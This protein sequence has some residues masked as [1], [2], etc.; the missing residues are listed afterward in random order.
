MQTISDMIA[1]I[2]R[3]ARAYVDR[4]P[5][6]IQG[7]NG[8]GKTWAVAIALARGFAL[9]ESTVLAILQDHN[10]SCDPPWSL[11]ELKHK[12]KDACEKSTLGCGYLLDAERHDMGPE[13]YA[14]SDELVAA[15]IANDEARGLAETAIVKHDP[16]AEETRIQSAKVL[17]ERS[18]AAKE[19][20]A[21]KSHDLLGRVMAL[22]GLCESFG[23]WVLRSSPYPQ[24][25]LVVG[26]ILALGSA[27]FQRRCVTSARGQLSTYILSIAKTGHGKNRLQEC[28]EQALHGWQEVRGPGD[29]SSTKSTIMR[30]SNTVTVHRTGLLLCIDEYGA[31]FSGWVNT[32]NGYQSEI[33][34]LLLEVGTK[35]LAPFIRPTSWAEG[36]A[37]ITI[38]APCLSIYGSSTPDTID[39]RG[40]SV[41]DGL[42]GRHLVF[43]SSP[44][45]PTRHH[46]ASRY[47]ET[48]VEVTEAVD[49]IKAEHK[50]WGGDQGTGYTPIVIE[51][52]L[53]VSDDFAAIADAI[54][55]IRRDSEDDLEAAILARSSE[56][57]RALAAILACLADVSSGATVRTRHQTLACEI[58]NVSM[59]NLSSLARDAESKT[60]EFG[61]A[62]ARI[63]KIIQGCPSGIAKKD[64]LRRTRWADP[65]TFASVIDNLKASEMIEE[66]VEK[67]PNGKARVSYLWRET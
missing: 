54:D 66:Q 42:A 49:K 6:A 7:D 24:P 39:F 28:I 2:E 5:G 10:K 50:V 53:V 48:P 8:S 41:A 16:T 13:E 9:P 21:E 17:T 36:G 51:E 34:S 26:A 22:G 37:D 38:I 45:L 20:K 18:I 56:R 55:D 4:M 29:L 1:H 33:R 60:S 57:S 32:R 52:D 15:M 30:M 62:S 46:N 11:R 47:S 40:S 61:S 43:C 27:L 58:V 59:G 35:G 14:A 23:G 44:R 25:E 65:K 19:A 67:S 3:R 64:L 63:A 31:K 12:A